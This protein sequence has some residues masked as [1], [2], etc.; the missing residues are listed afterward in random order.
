MLCCPLWPPLIIKQNLNSYS[1]KS[2]NFSSDWVCFEKQ[3]VNNTRFFFIYYYFLLLK[4]WAL[5]QFCWKNSN[6]WPKYLGIPLKSSITFLL[7][8]VKYLSFHSLTIPKVKIFYLLFLSHRLGLGDKTQEKLDPED[9]VNEFLSRAIDAR[10][11]DRLRSEHVKRVL[12]TFKDSKLEE[13]VSFHGDQ[14]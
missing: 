6:D 11:I 10:S 3:S 2:T 1:Q 4:F 9:E 12:L 13:K 14:W 7:P 8:S 5:K